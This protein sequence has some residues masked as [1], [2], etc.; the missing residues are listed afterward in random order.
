M[1]LNALGNVK[2]SIFE[3]TL[4]LPHCKINPLLNKMNKKESEEIMNYYYGLVDELNNGWGFVE[5][6]DPRVKPGFIKLTRQEWINLLNNQS[7]GEE[8]VFFD[9]KVFTT[10]ERGRYYNDAEGWHKKSDEVYFKEKAEAKQNEL[11]NKNFQIK[12]DKAYKGVIINDSLV[13]ETTKEAMS[14]TIATLALLDDDETTNWKFYN[15][16]GEPTV[17]KV[18]KMQ[19]A[20][21]A[22]LGRKM[23]DKCFEIEG[24]YNEIIKSATISDLNSEAWTTTIINQI[25]NEMDQVNNKIELTL[26]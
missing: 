25:Q 8:I 13:F 16:A 1:L 17:Q 7:A 5:E 26:L 9:G 22:K 24:R 11:I 2:I 23:I 19:V 6:T 14:T 3:L 10:P 21:I 15:K 12:A 20:A 4:T 18:T